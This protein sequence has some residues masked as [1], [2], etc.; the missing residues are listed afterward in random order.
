MYLDVVKDDQ[1]RPVL[2]TTQDHMEEILGNMLPEARER[3]LVTRGEDMS[4][5]TVE[6][7]LSRAAD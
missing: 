7:Y 4:E 1:D 5:Y 2:N 6:D 3:H